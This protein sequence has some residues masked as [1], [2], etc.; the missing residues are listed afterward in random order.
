MKRCLVVGIHGFL[1]SAVAARLGSSGWNVRG[2]CGLGDNLHGGSTLRYR[3]GIFSSEELGLGEM[4]LVVYAAGSVLPRHGVSLDDVRG[5]DVAPF[6][7]LVMAAESSPCAMKIVLFSSAGTLYGESS[8]DA[9]ATEDSPLGPISPYG[10]SRREMELL[11]MDSASRAPFTPVILRVSNAYGPGQTLRSGSSFVLRAVAAAV[12][13]TPLGLIGEGR[14]TKDFVFVDDVANAVGLVAERGTPPR[15]QR[16]VFNICSGRSWSLAEVLATVEQVTG[17]T[18]PVVTLAS[19]AGDVTAVHLS[20]AK[21]AAE[22]GW[23]PCV[24]LSDGIARLHDWL[25]R[26]LLDERPDSFVLGR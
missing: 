3:P 18:V 11:L 25:Q 1:G 21:A 8:A 22:L 7:E 6:G 14:A 26:H 5:C 19:Y 20:A 12:A 2:I 10:V 24:D 16:S 13:G 17:R 15:G 23:V 9:P 4:D